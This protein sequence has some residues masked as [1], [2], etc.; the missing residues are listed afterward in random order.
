MEKAFKVI[1]EMSKEGI[2]TDYAICGAVAT[3]YYTEPFDTYDVDI[4]FIP[5]EKEKIIILTPFYN[6]LLK[7]KKSYLI[8]K[9]QRHQRSIY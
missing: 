2:L 1:S 8:I 3:I 6:W 7:E 9:N 5:P 4:F